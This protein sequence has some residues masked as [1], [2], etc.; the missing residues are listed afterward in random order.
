MAQAEFEGLP[1]YKSQKQFLEQEYNFKQ[2]KNVDEN[3]I[4]SES[5]VE[6]CCCHRCNKIRIHFLVECM[7]NTIHQINCSDGSSGIHMIKRVFWSFWPKIDSNYSVAESLGKSIIFLNDDWMV[8][9]FIGRIPV[10]KALNF[11][12]IQ[13]NTKNRFRVSSGTESGLWSLEISI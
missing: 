2:T 11:I 4:K 10:L 9:K 8:V 6:W 1:V 12:Y 7:I 5:W 3:F 13:F